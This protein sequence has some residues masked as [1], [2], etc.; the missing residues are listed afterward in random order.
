[1]RAFQRSYATTIKRVIDLTRFSEE[2]DWNLWVPDLE[3]VWLWCRHHTRLDS[4]AAIGQGLV[5]RGRGLPKSA[6]TY[7]KHHIPGARRGFVHFGRDLEFHRLPEQFWLNLDPR[8]IRRPGTGITTAVPQVLLNYARVSR[9]PWRLKALIDREGHAV[10]SRFLTVRPRSPDLTL[11]FLWVLCNSP[12]ANAYAYAHSM[13]RDILAG[14][15]R[16]LPVP[17]VRRREIERVTEVALTYLHA[18]TP[19]GEPL[20]HQPDAN[21][22]RRLLMQMDAEVLR[23]YALPPRL[24]R[25]LLDLFAGWPREGVPFAFDR[26][27]PPDFEPCFSL[28]EYLSADLQQ[29]TAGRLRERHRPIDSPEWSAAMTATLDSFQE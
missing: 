24:E 20:T 12:L 6:I 18:V 2:N 27:F 25:Q 28:H 13:K 1:M 3:D 16:Q 10:T 9:G 23:L 17:S 22:G 4:L 5:F 11:E 7:Q 21:F 19:T 14:M 26:Y 8:V 29:S 15:M